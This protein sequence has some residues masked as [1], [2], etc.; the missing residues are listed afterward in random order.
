MVRYTS[1]KGGEGMQSEDYYKILQVH[2]QAEPEI[3]E[4]AY[5]R[6]ARKYHPD[7]NPA[8]C[9]DDRMQR[10]NEAY[11]VLS[12]PVKRK[13][14]NRLWESRIMNSKKRQQNTGTASENTP[15]LRF[16]AA[17]RLLEDY[18]DGLIKGAYSRSYET[19][20]EAD[21]RNISKSDFIQ[22]QTAVA[23]V[24]CMKEYKCELHG[25]YKDKMIRGMVYPLVLEFSVNTKERNLIM[26]ISQNDSITKLLLQEN[27]GWKVYLGYERLE[28]IIDKL[29]D[30]RGLLDSKAI[31]HDFL[32]NQ[33]RLDYSTGLINQR[34]LLEHIERE[35]LRKE[36]YHNVFSLILCEVSAVKLKKGGEEQETIN[37]VLGSMG[38]MLINNLRKLDLVGRWD[39]RHLLI[40]LPETGLVAAGRVLQKLQRLFQENNSLI[41]GSSKLVIDYSVTEYASSLEETL[42]KIYRRPRLGKYSS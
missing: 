7:V 42:D 36:R 31:I 35:I 3:I 10:I 11:S 14:Y 33:N 23:R 17:R 12:D 32:E 18:F 30:L 1:I 26:D 39:T 5:K 13:E 24:Y 4:S 19:I 21:K 16:L 40:V 28:P 9:Q 6:L 34:G 38:K 27:G 37:H 41:G 8:G 29:K 15:D 2:V 25:V 22:W 20:S